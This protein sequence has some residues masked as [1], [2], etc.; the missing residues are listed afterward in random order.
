MNALDLVYLP[1]ALVTA[2]WWGRKT[3]RDWPERF[4]NVE[5]VPARARPRILLHAVSVGETNALRHLVPALAERAHVIVSVGTDTG[6]RRARELYAGIA[7][8]VRYPLDFSWAVRRFLDA[9][10][11]DVV[12]LVELEVWPNFVAACRQRGIPVA[13]VNGRLSPRSFR[14]Y[15]RLRAFF[16][17]SF[18]SLAVVAAQDED[19]AARF[20]AMG[21]APE[22][23]RVTGSM[24][25]DAARIEDDVAGADALAREMGIV[26]GPGAPPIVVAGSTGPGEEALLAQACAKVEQRI[27]PVQLVCAP[28][29]PERFDEAAA[30]L[31][32]CVRRSQTKASVASTSTAA[33]SRRFLLDTIGELRQAYSLAD[34]VVV[35]RSFGG[36][37]GSDPIEPITLGKATIIGPAV[38]DF[39]TIVADF[40]RAG[41]L[42]R[43]TRE[44][45]AD[46]IAR[47]LADPRER[48]AL[49]SAGR[50]CIRERQG[51]SRTHA[52]VLLSLARD[53]L[54]VSAPCA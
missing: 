34:V 17:Y 1:L 14:G 23:V 21:V 48:A 15:R 18:G 41:G 19:Y 54:G 16:R 47:L 39:A 35:G 36:L 45:L 29:K 42:V 3:R 7:D 32:A 43:A 40:E 11:P 4:G 13:V 38:S 26:R 52:E 5:P 12:G 27:G 33:E 51:A 30:S 25:W 20:R 28:R 22:R 50:A 46:T 2:P 6:I 8:V 53:S 24:K 31:G 10:R 44:T 49:A 37:F 9:T